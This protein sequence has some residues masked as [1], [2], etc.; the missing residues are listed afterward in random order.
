[1][2]LLPSSSPSE[3]C[4]VGHTGSL[5]HTPSSEE[6]SPTKFPRLNSTTELS[7]HHKCLYE[8]PDVVS[9]NEKEHE[10]K[11]GKFKKKEK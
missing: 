10:K 11:K 9:D 4:Q 2:F 7:P 8:P 5:A 6:I 1:C 3:H